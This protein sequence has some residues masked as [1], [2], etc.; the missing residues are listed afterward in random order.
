MAAGVLPCMFVPGGVVT[1]ISCM[2]VSL[3]C[4]SR[5]GE[6]DNGKRAL[7]VLL[8]ARLVGGDD[9][10]ADEKDKVLVLL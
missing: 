2:R 8:D 6:C 1:L 10:G 3:E 5:M 9:V 4:V 7:P